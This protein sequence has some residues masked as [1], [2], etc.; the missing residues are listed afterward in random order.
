MMKKSLKG[1]MNSLMDKKIINSIVYRTCSVIFHF[2][3]ISLK[4]NLYKAAQKVFPFYVYLDLYFAL[5]A[6]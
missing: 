6:F 4:A 3:F 1:T 2:Y 5:G